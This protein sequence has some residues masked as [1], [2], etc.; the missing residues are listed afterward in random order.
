[1]S[2]TETGVKVAEANSAERRG[3]PATGLRDQGFSSPIVAISSGL[4]N[5]GVYLMKWSQSRI[6]ENGG[7]SLVGVLG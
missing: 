2:D 6:F 3:N 1:M 5:Q 4:R 7:L